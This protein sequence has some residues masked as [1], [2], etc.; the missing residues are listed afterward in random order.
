M[1]ASPPDG[2]APSDAVLADAAGRLG[3]A[4]RA[5][6]AKLATAE[7]CTGGWIAKVVTDI[8]GSSEWFGAGF[9][10]YSNAAKTEMLGVDAG[11][12][13]EH[14]AVSEA[15]VRAMA[16][17]AK[18]RAGAELAVAVSGVAGPAGGTPAKP[19]GTVWFAWDT[20]AGIETEHRRFAGDRDAVRRRAVARALEGLEAALSTR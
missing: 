7:S 19:V 16:A 18:R 2:A 11:V 10:T 14:G 20:P 13:A 17:G 1:S 15:V 4:L 6:G 3:A 5:A 9:V 12:L 8:A